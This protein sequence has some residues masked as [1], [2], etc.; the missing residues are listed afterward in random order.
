MVIWRSKMKKNFKEAIVNQNEGIII[1]NGIDGDIET[2]KC[3]QDLTHFQNYVDSAEKLKKNK[4]IHVPYDM[5]HNQWKN[6]SI[7]D[8][9][10]LLSPFL[11]S[12]YIPSEY[13]VGLD[14]D[15]VSEINSA[16]YEEYEKSYNILVEYCKKIVQNFQ[17]NI[18]VPDR[19]PNNSYRP[20][21]H[22]LLDE[23][24][25]D[26][27]REIKANHWTIVPEIYTNSYSSRKN[28]V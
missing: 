22:Y 24:I 20:I 1:V 9:F 3:L 27:I 10:N 23:F 14:D 7:E 15:V 5:S 13:L 11:P 2:R 6:A 18:F 19:D 25:N 16:K 8:I 28:N 4:S 26:V 12:P 21:K 17:E